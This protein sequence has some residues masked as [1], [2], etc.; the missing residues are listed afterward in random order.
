[1]RVLVDYTNWKGNRGW[2][3]VEPWT[4]DIFAVEQGRYNHLDGSSETTQVIHVKM[5]D[6]SDA[7]RTLKLTNI[8]GIRVVL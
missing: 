7:R 1:M 6:R 5:A 4:G 3:E 2:R 8:H